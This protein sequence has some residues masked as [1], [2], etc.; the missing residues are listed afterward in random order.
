MDDGYNKSIKDINPQTV[1]NGV[2]IGSSNH[3][4]HQLSTCD[5]DRVPM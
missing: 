2:N 4:F 1:N 3:R 5:Y